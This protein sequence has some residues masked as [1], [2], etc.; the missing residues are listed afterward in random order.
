MGSIT[1]ATSDP[2]GIK[3]NPNLGDRL[4]IQIREVE[5]KLTFGV[6]RHF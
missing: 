1:H 5:T 3:R 2:S 6:N 4:P